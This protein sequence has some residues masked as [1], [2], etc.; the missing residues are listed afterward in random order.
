MA[1][2]LVLL[3]APWAVLVVVLAVVVGVGRRARPQNTPVATLLAARR[4][5]N[6]TS[7]LALA[8]GL[9]VAVLLLTAD[10]AALPGPPGGLTAVSLLGA[11]LAAL[12]VHAV[13]ELTWPRPVGVVRHASLRRRTM[14][15]IGGRRVALAGATAALAALALVV[16]GLTADATGRAVPHPVTPLAAGEGYVSGASGPYPGWA[17]G[18]PLLAALTVVL[19]VGAGVLRL[20]V[21]RP[22]VAGTREADDL[23]LRRT[24]ARRV[25]AAVQLVVGGTLAAVLLVAAAAL[26]NA[27]WAPAAWG[28]GGLALVVGTASLVAAG[29]AIVPP[30]GPPAAGSPAAVP[31][32]AAPPAAGTPA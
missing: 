15:A 13:G 14:R 4:H 5:E 29:T 7:A 16:F 12:L 6:L 18:L 26:G 9:A 19:A 27:G 23:A 17:Y 25:L 10:A 28:A 3:L 31:P 11:G 24:S 32:A 30:P 21:R 2:A 20:V 22:A 1:V 8:G